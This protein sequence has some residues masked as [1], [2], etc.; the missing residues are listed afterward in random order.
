MY[1]KQQEL[2][3]PIVAGR[4]ATRSC[5]EPAY[6]VLGKPY[7]RW[8]WFASEIN[9]EDIDVQIT[10]IREN[11]FGGVE[12]SFVYPRNDDEAVHPYLGAEWQGAVAYC[13]TACRDAG[14]GFDLTFGSLWPF[15]GSMIGESD[16]SRTYAGLSDQRLRR[17]WESGEGKEPGFIMN[18]LDRRALARYGSVVAPALRPAL[19]LW[20]TGESPSRACLF[21]D[22]WEVHV[23]GLWTD[24]LGDAF[25]SEFGYRV[26][27]YLNRID[28][29]PAVRY[30]YRRLIARVVLEEFY[31]PLTKTCHEQGALSR[32]QCHGAPTDLIAAY[33]AVDV[34]ESE[35]LLFDPPFSAFA[36]SA[37]AQSGAPVVA[38]ESFTCLYGWE[39]WP[40]P[41][42]HQGEEYWPDIRLTADAMFANGVNHIVWHGMPFRPNDRPSRFYASVHLGP[43]AAYAA[44][45]PALN[46]YFA[47]ISR[48][49]QQGVLY[50][51]L[52]VYQP[53]EDVFRK[54]RLPHADRRPS[55]EYHW[56]MQ[57][58][59]FPEET[60]PY[61]PVWTSEHYLSGARVT[62]DGSVA[63][64]VHRAR[65]LYVTSEYVHVD[66]LRHMVRLA[67]EGACIVLA[68]DP[69]SPGRV[70]VAEYESL[71]HELRAVSLRTL[72]GLPGDVL[73]P[74]VMGPD[75]PQYVAR[76]VRPDEAGGEKR[77]RLFFAHP[78][79]HRI[80]Y[81]LEYRFS[82]EANAVR[83]QVTISWRG[84]SREVTLEF[85]SCEA[86]MVELYVT[87][88][89]TVTH[90]NSI[91]ADCGL[92]VRSLA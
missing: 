58:V 82:D 61:S 90:G 34:P 19:D 65:A 41:G 39:R 53:L 70:P 14:I 64:G 27:P 77:L 47:E 3:P 89:V 84:L 32:V 59:R 23:D 37:A 88:E 54:G 60:R 9:R 87:G 51:P 8:W 78:L 73:P 48:L 45:I 62:Q 40:G 36:T 25:A 15:G 33:S 18:H 6:G 5:D 52:A 13:A 2:Q 66:S 43:D 30:D 38:C 75:L 7:V 31:R 28:E 22:S 63:L 49:M 44:Q 50:A 79:A 69:R 17:S 20:N 4:F 24:G 76:E 68:R 55:A 1:D 71:V 85:G 92:E 74:V 29:E 57:Y 21:C 16:A 11:G 67:R 10:W 12:L 42:P 46:G 83:K 26:E 72:D 56:E 80:R 86:L 81:P 35:T 91:L